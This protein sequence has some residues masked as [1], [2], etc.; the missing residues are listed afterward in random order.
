MEKLAV[1][2]RK[3]VRVRAKPMN[4]G[5]EDDGQLDRGNLQSLDRGRDLGARSLRLFVAAKDTRRGG[6]I[7]DF[8]KYDRTVDAAL[9]RGIRPQLVLDS[10][11][12]FSNGGDPHEFAKFTRAAARHFKG[13]VQRYSL[14][15]EPDLRMSPDRYRELYIRGRRGVKAVD[16]GAQVLFGE[17]SA[18]DPVAY[19][20]KVL[21]RGSLRADGFAFHP[22]Q[23]QQDPM[24]PGSL[25]GG[26]GRLG[27]VS[28]ELAKLNIRTPMGRTP[29]LYLTEFGYA[30]RGEHEVS[31]NQAAAWWPR[32]LRKAEGAHVR[33]LIAYHLTQ[34]PAAAP[35][36]TSLIDEQGRARPAYYALAAALKR[37]Q[38]P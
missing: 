5:F 26:I 36:D 11:R 34:A 28:H 4:V 16:G 20:R 22:Y 18:H 21:K 23:F 27:Q 9:Q 7:Y 19:T 6:G 3:V 32:A 13:R 35:W 38:S 17:L 24:A 31:Q 33:Q 1:A 10:A 2:K 12:D 8:A 30:T 15:N 37:R 29:G 14:I 25:R